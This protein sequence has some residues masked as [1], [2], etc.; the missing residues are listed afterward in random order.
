MA[1]AK[2]TA[3]DALAATP[4]DADL[5]A[6]V[7]DVAGTPVTKKVTVANLM[8]AAGATSLSLMPKPVEPTI[9]AGASAP[10]TTTA[11]V[12]RIDIP[13]GITV[14]KLTIRTGATVTVAGTY[15]IT[16]YSD[17]GQTKHIAITTASLAAADTLYSTAV[18]SVVLPA[19]SYYIMINA[20][21]TANVEIYAWN[22]GSAAPFK[23][24][25]G[26]TE[27]VTDEPVYEGTLTITADTPPA[28]INPTAITSN[29]DRTLLFRLDN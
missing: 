10:T 14:N 1:D 22:T 24:T 17:D 9:S 11:F 27:D 25:E 8:A 18:S 4:D 3:L 7:D 21:S 15:D 5:L 6:V 13:I 23:G 12:G 26:I 28:T 16:L 2:I 19:G 29:Q 20:N